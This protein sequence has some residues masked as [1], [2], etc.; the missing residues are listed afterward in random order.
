[1][2]NTL[3]WLAGSHVLEV[4]NAHVVLPKKLNYQSMEVK[5]P[6]LESDTELKTTGHLTRN[7][8]NVWSEHFFPLVWRGQEIDEWELNGVNAPLH[9]KHVNDVISVSVDNGCGVSGYIDR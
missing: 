8:Q 3:L 9:I 7:K 5:L 4:F 2:V 6:T 1:M